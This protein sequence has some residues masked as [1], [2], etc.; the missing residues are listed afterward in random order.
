MYG[1]ITEIRCVTKA[2]GY[3]DVFEVIVARSTAEITSH[4]HTHTP[5]MIP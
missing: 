5:A 4:G 1:V 2:E 3:N